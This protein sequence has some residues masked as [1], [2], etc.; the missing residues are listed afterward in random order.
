MILIK[1]IDFVVLMILPGEV[2]TQNFWLPIT[3][4]ISKITKSADRDRELTFIFDV[5][6]ESVIGFV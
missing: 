3:A 2:L 6:L 4:D 5:V 1:A